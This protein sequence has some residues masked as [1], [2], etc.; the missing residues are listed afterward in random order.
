MPESALRA[1]RRLSQVFTGFCALTETP[2]RGAGDD[3]INSN[4]IGSNANDYFGGQL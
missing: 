3:A 1:A 2:I 4:G